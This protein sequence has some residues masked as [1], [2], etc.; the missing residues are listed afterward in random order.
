[1][2]LD[3]IAH[4]SAFDYQRVLEPKGRYFMVGGSVATMFQLLVLGPWF[5]RTTSKKLG[6]LAV[7]PR[8]EDMV[9]MTELMEAGQVVPVIDK[10][11]SLSQV[12]EALRYLGE[13]RAIG[14]VVILVEHPSKS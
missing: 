11:Y 5:R 7:P 9:S 8:V 13:G 14:K 12:P 6:L 10:R 1:M 3:L 2:I 4:R